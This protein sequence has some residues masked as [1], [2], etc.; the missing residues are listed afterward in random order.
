MK[1]ALALALITVLADVPPTPQSAIAYFR[2]VRDVHIS[3]PGKQNYFLIDEE[4]WSHSRSDLSDLRLYD[5]ELPVQYALSQQ[6]EGFSSDEVEAKLLNLGLVS[7]HTEFDLD[8][9][10]LAEYN[11]LRLRL[12]AHD[13]VA[14]ASVSGGDG[15]GKAA[16]VQLPPSTLYDFRK[17]Q[18]GSNSVLRL[19]I[20]SFRFLHV[21]VAGGVRPEN[22]KGASVFQQHERQA[23][24]TK[25]GSCAA[26]QQ[27]GRSTTVTCNVSEK[28]PV[29]RI[30]F[31]VAPTEVNFRRS[32]IVE[33]PN[34]F[35]T[36]GGDITRVRLNRGG[37]LVTDE[38]MAIP[39]PG[40]SGQITVTID[41]GDNSPLDIKSVQPLVTEHRLY[42]DPQGRANLKLY[43]GD[44]KLSAPVY[45]YA[46]F[47]HV[48]PLLALAEL[49]SASHNPSYTGRPDDRPWSERHTTILWAVMLLT[50][51]A[52]AFLAFRGLRIAG[53]KPPQI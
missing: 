49:G 11:R 19:P 36:V 22:V 3:D 27:K 46:R 6:G 26:P 25:V 53:P 31:E 47:F 4:I 9:Q 45:D 21:K 35:R 44:E 8:M 38:Q 12:D 33:V 40:I 39:A 24:W 17:E 52:L 28:V 34:G 42:F 5:G 18:L 1:L 32:V 30:A 2:K 50:V 14:T 43:Y 13:F 15:P 7:G 29:S 20:S 10:G 23:S 37:T 48:E 41:N 51:L 16:S